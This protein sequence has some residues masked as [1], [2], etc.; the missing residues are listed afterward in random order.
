MWNISK[1]L[2]GAEGCQQED[3]QE[4]GI[5]L[6]A[7][8]RSFIP[9]LMTFATIVGNILVLAA[10]IFSSRLPTTLLIANLA[11]ADLLVGIVIMPLAISNILTESRWIYGMLVCRIWIS[12]DVI[13]CTASI[14][15]LCAI[16]AD[17]FIGVTRPLQ[18]AQLVTTKRVFY[19]CAAIWVV[20]IMILLATLRWDSDQLEECE[21]VS[22]KCSVGDQLQ[23]VVESTVG[24]FFIPLAVICLLYYQ[25]FQVAS[26]KQHSLFSCL[27]TAFTKRSVEQ[28]MALLLPL[29]IHYGRPNGEQQEKRK[30]ALRKHQKTA[31]TLGVVVGAFIICWTPFFI[32]HSLSAL[33]S[34]EL[35]PGFV[36]DFFTWLGYF[37]SAL[38]P[39]IYGMTMRSFKESFRYFAANRWWLF[40]S[41]RPFR[42]RTSI[43]K[44]TER[45][46]ATR[47]RHNRTFDM[48]V[49]SGERY[50]SYDTEVAPVRLEV[51]SLSI[52]QERSASSPDPNDEL[53]KSGTALPN[54]AFNLK[55]Y[56]LLISSK[57]TDL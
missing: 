53:S 4:V 17:R 9:A 31:K 40:N 13:C 36:M 57:A 21:Q 51:C 38:N 27:S 22:Q 7:L 44:S 39:L 41:I 10:I 12:L 54:G 30:R 42:S 47:P 25:I 56:K 52:Q 6:I 3:V 28:R 46:R 50:I 8:L 29:R 26:R 37:N 16:S 1:E 34:K 43:E 32:L 45:T 20:S 5:Q 33:T 19:S 24:S 35:V 49:S 55:L 23:Y 2:F 11:F 15:T 14:V 48:E 18:Y